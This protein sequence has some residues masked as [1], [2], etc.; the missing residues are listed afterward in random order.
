MNSLSS[1]FTEN[2][3]ELFVKVPALFS[4][5]SAVIQ[6]ACGGMAVLIQEPAK[7]VK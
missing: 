1:D 7:H 4:Q 2:I 3:F 6:V 5:N